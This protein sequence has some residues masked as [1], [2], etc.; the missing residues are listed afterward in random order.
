[1]KE[2]LNILIKVVSSDR[3]INQF[4]FQATCILKGLTK[5]FK[6]SSASNYLAIEFS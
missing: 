3:L 6:K 5:L 2:I 1:M 4:S